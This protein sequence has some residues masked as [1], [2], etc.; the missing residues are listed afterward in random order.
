MTTEPQLP[1]CAPCSKTSPKVLC[2]PLQR[3]LFPQMYR[4]LSADGMSSDVEDR[5]MLMKDN[6][7][8]TARNRQTYKREAETMDCVEL[9]VE[10]GVQVT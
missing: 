2:N 9:G 7:I 4:R 5:L 1:N 8:K 10:H 6:L 3:P